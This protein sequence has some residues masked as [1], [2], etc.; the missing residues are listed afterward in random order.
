M[1]AVLMHAYQILNSALGDERVPVCR[2]FWTKITVGGVEDSLRIV[3]K[4]SLW[5]LG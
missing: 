1:P 5:G 4:M 2:V 3:M